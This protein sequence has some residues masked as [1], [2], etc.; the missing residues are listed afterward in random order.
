MKYGAQGGNYG[1][2]NGNASLFRDLPLALQNRGNNRGNK[3]SGY[4]PHGGLYDPILKGKD[5]LNLHSCVHFSC[6]HTRGCDCPSAG[7]I[8][9]RIGLAL[10]LDPAFGHG[11]LSRLRNTFRVLPRRDSRL[12]L[13]SRCP[14]FP[15]MVRSPETHIGRRCQNF[16]RPGDVK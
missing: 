8:C 1:R 11:D 14:S 3:G 13:R 16:L 4:C 7:R 15:R 2:I 5:S 12:V 6:P 9:R 10:T